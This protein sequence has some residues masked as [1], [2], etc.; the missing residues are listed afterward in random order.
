MHSLSRFSHVFDLG[1]AV[2][3]Y[4]SLR[5]KPVFLSKDTYQSLRDY[6]VGSFCDSQ[7]PVELQSVITQLQKYKI[8]TNTPEEDEKV[9]QFVRG[10]VP[11]PRINVC[12]MILSEQCN[13]AC[14][15]CFLGNNDAKKR[16]HFN[17]QNMTAETADKGIA[18]FIRQIKNSSPLP[19][20]NKPILI[21][22]GGEPLVNYSTLVYI[23]KKINTLREVE[24]CIKNLEMS[25]ITNGI[26]LDDEKIQT[27]SDL[28]VGIGIS[29]DGFTEEENQMRVDTSGKTTFSRVLTTLNRCK[30]LG[31]NV[32]LSVTLSEETVRHP[33]HV[34]NLIKEYDIQ[35]LGFN[36][37]MSSDTFNVSNQYNE[38]ASQFIID[39]FVDLRKLGVYEDRMM[40]K[41]DAFAKSQIYF[42]DCAATSGGQIVI[43]PDGRVGICH[44]CLYNKDYFISNVSDAQFDCTQD[45]TFK[46]WASLTPINR[47][48]CLDC[49]A[50]G[51]CGGGCPINA[52]SLKAG[53][54]IHSMDTRFCVHSKKTL[55]FLIHDLYRIISKNTFHQ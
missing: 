43:A 5:M 17:L 29:I 36:I 39:T 7:L 51:I 15:Y 38:D 6:L 48:E 37:L 50:L 18:Y 4:H 42:S 9:L 25:V 53:N 28:G 44:G 2:A 10:M 47:N 54:T 13:L 46:E 30:T 12:Y 41:L 40:R 1:D 27:L 52:R 34:L 8:I 20:T 16:S 32:S 26:L 11:S 3:L 14:K 23:A 19:S 35:S 33:Q 31:V 49:P 45:G 24:P 55:E 22:Y 21:F